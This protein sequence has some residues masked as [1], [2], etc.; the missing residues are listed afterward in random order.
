MSENQRQYVFRRLDEGATVEQIAFDPDPASRWISWS[1]A[2]A[3]SKEWRNAKARP[4]PQVLT[5]STVKEER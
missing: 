5:D 1:Y 4:S 2:L 3:L